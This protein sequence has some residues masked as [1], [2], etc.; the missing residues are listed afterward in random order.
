[1]PIISVLRPEEAVD[2]PVGNYPLCLKPRNKGTVSGSPLVCHR[3]LPQ[4]GNVAAVRNW[5]NESALAE[6]TTTNMRANAVLFSIASA[7]F[8][9]SSW[10]R[11]CGAFRLASPDGIAVKQTKAEARSLAKIG[12]GAGASAGQD[13][14]FAGSQLTGGESARRESC[15]QHGCKQQFFRHRHYSFP[16]PALYRP[17]ASERFAAEILIFATS[18]SPRFFSL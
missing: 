8:Q 12:S 17:F 18:D 6:R 10:P 13:C 1:V 3:G 4:A 2:P 7:P 5:R 16:P 15:R 14:L 11:R 9:V